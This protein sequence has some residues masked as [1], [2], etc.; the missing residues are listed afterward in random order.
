MSDSGIMATAK[1]IPATAFAAGLRE[2]VAQYKVARHG[3]VE[4]RRGSY[5]AA[6][7]PRSRNQTPYGGSGDMQFDTWSRRF[8]RELS[9]DMDRNADTF[10]VLADAFTCAVVGSGVKYRPTTSDPEWNKTAAKKMDELMRRTRNGVDARQI[11][12][13]YK[14]QYDMV[15][16]FVV[17]GETG[18][19]KLMGGTVQPFESDQL[20][21]GH[22][23]VFASADG[24]QTDEA[25]R[26]TKYN[27]CPYQYPAGGVEISEGTEFPAEDVEWIA[28]HSRFSQT[29]GTPMLVASLDDWERLDSFRESEIIAAEQGSQI[30]GVFE[31]PEGDLGT[32]NPFRTGDADVNPSDNVQGGV[33]SNA[34][35]INWQPTVAGAIM[36]LPRGIKYVP[37]NPQRPNPE[38]VTFLMELIRQFC[39]NVGLPYEIIYNDVRGL[40]WSVNRALVQMARDRVDVWQTQFFGPMLSNV[41][42]FLMERLI[43]EGEIPAH[44]EWEQHD[45]A[46][47]E[48]SW[49]DEGAEFEA[50]ERGLLRGLTT[51]HRIHGPHW[52]DY[53]DERAEELRYAA[54]LATVYNKTY[55]DFPV[56]PMFMLGFDDDPSLSQNAQEEDPGHG[57]PES[58]RQGPNTGGNNTTQ[59]RQRKEYQPQGSTR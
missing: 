56:S 2:R 13:G 30:Y 18:L 19:I 50:Q 3:A 47:C 25:G 58:R 7:N 23:D 16:A 52:R 26:V 41:Y 39:A 38:A 54:E 27:I 29:R 46:W 17:D 45:L 15:R 59:K 14:I 44:K 8:L 31:H 40:S 24:V 53:L 34:N 5:R 57:N 42:T 49:P 10:R 12:S 22:P 1:P 9:R 4:A 6:A 51:R 36:D 20:T 43:S 37:V 21:G 11:R 35:N 55:P 32:S 33:S 28:N 48:I